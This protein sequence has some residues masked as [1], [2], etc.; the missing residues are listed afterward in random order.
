[1]PL[2]KPKPPVI[3]IDGESD[4]EAALSEVAAPSGWT[5]R[6]DFSLPDEPWDLSAHR[7]VCSGVVH[8]DEQA[9]V[10]L[11]ALAR[12]VGLVVALKGTGSFRLRVL[13]DLHH[14][15]DVVSQAD[16]HRPVVVPGPDDAALL[17]SLADGATVEEAARRVS[18]STRTAHRRLAALR[19]AYR[20]TNTT[21]AVTHWIA[22]GRPGAPPTR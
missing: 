13:D 6:D 15:G 18:L 4:P 10:A 16:H 1:V 20:A 14:N 9:K 8:D 7:W 5:R 11:S 12:G 2:G 3:L 22:D 19:A 17:E 21:E